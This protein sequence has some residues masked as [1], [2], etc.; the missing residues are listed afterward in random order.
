MIILV[1]NNY[2]MFRKKFRVLQ[3]EIDHFKQ[4]TKWLEETY[5]RETSM[6][7]E[8]IANRL[9][10]IEYQLAN[11]PKYS[12]GERVKNNKRKFIVTDVEVVLPMHRCHV[13]NYLDRIHKR[14]TLTNVKTGSVA[15]LPEHL[16]NNSH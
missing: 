10:K 7:N 16:I 12:I 6:R 4:S 8:D 3:Q 5:K 2:I 13:G 1:T 14:Y 15:Y 9:A 11:P